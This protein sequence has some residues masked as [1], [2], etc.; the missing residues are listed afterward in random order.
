[1]LLIYLTLQQENG[2]AVSRLSRGCQPVKYIGHA[3]SS[4]SKATLCLLVG[5]R[6]HNMDVAV[7]GRQR[8]IL[9]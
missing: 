2:L 8:Q 3:C 1:M 4:R 7:R 5:L 9:L 6:L